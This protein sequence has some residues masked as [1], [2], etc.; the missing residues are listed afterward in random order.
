MKNF[1]RFSL[2]ALVVALGC[3]PSAFDQ[4]D[5][6]EVMTTEL[7]VRSD[8]SA[9]GGPFQGELAACD[10]AGGD[11]SGRSPYHFWSFSTDG[12]DD[13]LVDLASRA[14]DDTY[15]LLY[16]QQGAAWRLIARNDDCTEG[17]LNSCFEGSLS[18]GNYLVGVATYDY[19]RWGIPT[20]AEYQLRVVCRDGD[21]CDVTPEP[22]ACGSRGLEAC[23]E[24]QYC[25]WAVEAMCGATDVPGVCRPVPD[26]CTREYAPVCGCDGRDYSNACA[27]AQHGISVQGEGTC[28]VVGG[29]AGDDCGGLVGLTCGE[30][31][32]CAYGPG[33]LCGAA[34]ALGTCAWQPEVCTAL[35]DPVCGCDGRTYSNSCYAAS[36]GVSVSHD[37]ECPAPGNGEGEICG[38]IAGFRCAAGLACDMSIND[39]C[40]ADLAGVCVVDDGL[41]YCTREYMPVCGCNGV[42]YNNDCERRAAMVA[43]DHE[44]ACR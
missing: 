5:T 1:I 25:D 19:M 2:P 15:L 44:G 33:D 6:D 39:F 23:P 31:L 28:P 8:S 26:A 22:Q 37:G 32:F 10:W 40:G 18:A 38:G 35:W 24:G 14:G 12:C 11:L 16:R 42:T 9:D 17:T 34:D 13:L 30:G 41:G 20:A 7:A 21:E 36:A 43:L 27:A 4:K 3:A 29:E